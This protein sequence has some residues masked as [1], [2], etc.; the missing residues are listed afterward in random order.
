MLVLQFNKLAPAT[1]EGA[2][3][4]TDDFLCHV[5]TLGNIIINWLSAFLKVGIAFWS[6]AAS[7]Y[8][9]LKYALH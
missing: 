4:S 1:Q 7:L 8:L 2:F 6:E 5:S 3:Q 9:E